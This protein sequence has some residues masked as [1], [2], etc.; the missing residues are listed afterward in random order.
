MFI[1]P[2]WPAPSNIKSLCTTRKGGVS[3]APYSEFNLATHVG[4][5]HS[6]VLANRQRLIELAQLPCEPVWLDQQHTDHIID[7]RSP[8]LALSGVPPVADASWSDQAGV[9][10]AVMTA[11]CLPLLVTNLSGSVVLAIHAGWKGLAKGIVT[12]S[13]MH[14]QKRPENSPDQLMV[15]IG[16]AI[17]QQ[18]FEV[19]EEVRQVFVKQVDSN[20]HFFH[21][22]PDSESN[23]SEKKYLA[24]LPGLAK[25]ELNRFGVDQVYGGD[26][27]AFAN[28]E[29]FYSYRRNPQTGRMAS[30]IWMESPTD[31]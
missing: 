2:N 24:D 12:K 21:P 4:D 8:D 3:Q 30:L 25:A 18:H 13:L 26:L 31:K 6:D 15:W 11:D 9:V 1:T 29:L 7:L 14:L 5:N 23:P 22:L 19:G 10:S 16:P 17:S 27:C 20:K 28:E